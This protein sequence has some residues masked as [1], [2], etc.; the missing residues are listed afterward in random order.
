MRT[1]TEM[2]IT[3]ARLRDEFN[4][5]VAT[6]LE[7][8][9]QELAAW[10]ELAED[11]VFERQCASNN[12][13]AR[14]LISGELDQLISDG[15]KS[16]VAAEKIALEKLGKHPIPTHFSPQKKLF[17]PEQQAAIDADLEIP[18]HVLESAKKHAD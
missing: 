6:A 13:L 5:D 1:E 9:G 16:A 4:V 17:T 18:A 11:A 2:Q 15:V 7:L 14:K 8:Q 12:E 10:L 3:L